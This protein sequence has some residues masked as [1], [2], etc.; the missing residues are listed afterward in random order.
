MNEADASDASMPEEPPIEWAWEMLE[1][2]VSEELASRVTAS[3]HRR[4]VTGELV[5]LST[6][7]FGFLLLELARLGFQPM[8]P[9]SLPPSERR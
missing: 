9:S 6:R 2:D 4:E 7:G 5:S 8:P 1:R 3:I